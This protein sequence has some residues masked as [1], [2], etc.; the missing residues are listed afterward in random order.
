MCVPTDPPL[1]VGLSDEHVN[2]VSGCNASLLV[3]LEYGFLDPNVTWSR[4]QTGNS[5]LEEIV[6]D[7]SHY[8]FSGDHG[9][10]LTVID[11]AVADSGKYFLNVT[12]TKATASLW[13]QVSVLGESALSH[14]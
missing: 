6:A 14:V 1:I 2:F 3:R 7:G 12:S 10:N 13:F 8:L 5:K 9:L 4:Q 11:V